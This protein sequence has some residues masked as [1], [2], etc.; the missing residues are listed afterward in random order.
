MK[1]LFVLCVVFLAAIFIGCQENLITDPVEDGSAI[2]SENNFVLDK[3]FI[4]Y[5]PKSIRIEGYLP[6]PSH[7]LNGSVEIKGLLRY[8]QDGGSR[9]PN[10]TTSHPPVTITMD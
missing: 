10:Y 2:S 7:S 1:K 5:L 3:D 9:T 8:R 4:S 6:D